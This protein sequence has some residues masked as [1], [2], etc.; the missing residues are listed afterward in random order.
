MISSL[1]SP[2]T[3][4]AIATFDPSSFRM[5]PVSPGCP[6]ETCPER[7]RDGP[8]N[9]RVRDDH[10]QYGDGPKRMETVYMAHQANLFG[11]VSHIPG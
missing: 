2:V 9:A 3:V 4:P 6:P 1:V 10:Q 11:I 8:G 7:F 5:D